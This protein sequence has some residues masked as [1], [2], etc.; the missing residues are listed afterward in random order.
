MVSDTAIRDAGLV[1]QSSPQHQPATWGTW[2]GCVCR[3]PASDVIVW[4]S[5]SLWL[6]WVSL[7]VQSMRVYDVEDGRVC[8]CVCVRVRVCGR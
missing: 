2:S 3:R 7:S 5:L 1:K 8:V 4:V 6:K